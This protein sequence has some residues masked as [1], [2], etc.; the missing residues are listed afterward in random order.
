MGGSIKIS[1]AAAISK[2]PLLLSSEQKTGEC[3]VAIL[4]LAGIAQANIARTREH[5]SLVWTE[6]LKSLSRM[7]AKMR[8]TAALTV[9]HD[10]V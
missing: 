10:L 8:S 2:E 5:F 3:V 6:S 1:T 4:P 7:V 9:V